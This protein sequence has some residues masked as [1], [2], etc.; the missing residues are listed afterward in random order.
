MKH[1]AGSTLPQPYALRVTNSHFLL[2]LVI[3][4]W[5]EDNCVGKWSLDSKKDDKDIRL[6]FRDYSDITLFKLSR[7]NRLVKG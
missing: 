2:P 1:H 3:E 7:Y 4:N 6:S 5:C